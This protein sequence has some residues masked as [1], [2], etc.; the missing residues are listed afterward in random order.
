MN[1]NE[2]KNEKFK[3]VSLNAIKDS[4][5]QPIRNLNEFLMTD[6]SKVNN[7]EITKYEYSTTKEYAINHIKGFNTS[8]KKINTIETR[9]KRLFAL[10]KLI[11]TII[12]QFDEEN[13][14]AFQ[15]LILFNYLRHLKTR[16]KQFLDKSLN[17]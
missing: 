8:L 13:T 2:I 1:S 5:I 16:A 4:Y 6:F 15:K 14:M 12:N 10:I 7:Q 11:N 9:E 17:L 3:S